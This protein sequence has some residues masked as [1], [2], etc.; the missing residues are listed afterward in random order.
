LNEPDRLE[1][2]PVSLSGT[3]LGVDPIKAATPT[4]NISRRSTTAALAT[5]MLVRII[6]CACGFGA[7]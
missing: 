2:G 7:G 3:P 4:V 5:V 1:V 6:E